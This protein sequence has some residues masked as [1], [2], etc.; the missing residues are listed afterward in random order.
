MRSE[1]DEVI[2]TSEETKTRLRMLMELVVQDL[3]KFLGNVS[4]QDKAHNRNT[5]MLDFITEV[6]TL[7]LQTR[8]T[9]R[10][11]LKML[12]AVYEAGHAAGRGGDFKSLL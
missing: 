1:E 11:L 4:P 12:I 9:D 7:W 6:A 8:Q 10:Q 3:E 5:V 2:T